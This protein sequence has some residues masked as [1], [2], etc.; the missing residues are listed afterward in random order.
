MSTFRGRMKEFPGVCVDYFDKPD[1]ETLY[2]L[3]HCH[4]DHMIGIQSLSTIPNAKLIVSKMT[5]SILNNVYP[6]LEPILETI[7]T[8]NE[9]LYTLT[10]GEQILCTAL[11][12]GHCPGSV[13]FYFQTETVNVLYTGDFRWKTSDLKQLKILDRIKQD[14]NAIYIDSTF[15][16]PEF[17]EFPGQKDSVGVVEKLVN[18]WLKLSPNNNRVFLEI[19]ARFGSEYLLLELYKRLHL[20]MH[21]CDVDQGCLLPFIPEM[22]HFIV[23]QLNDSVKIVVGMR[24]TQL[25]PRFQ[26]RRI[27]PSAMYWANWKQGDPVMKPDDHRRELFR[28]CYSSHSSC[29]EIM[30]LLNLLQPHSINL[31][32]L[33][34]GHK[35]RRLDQLKLFKLDKLQQ[36][37]KN[38]KATVDFSVVDLPKISFAA[39]YVAPVGDKSQRYKKFL[40]QIKADDSDE[41]EPVIVLP[42]RKRIRVKE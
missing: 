31:N 33:P 13:M 29:S 39:G 25:N 11:P 20:D 36:A 41:E 2:F 15:M 7:D 40:A 19:P 17:N 38:K 27:R 26:W 32:V 16:V 3:S 37:V 23:P 10:N 14:L 5:Q 18:E 42:I 9:K 21:L 8:G 6:E 1:E 30:A 12:A 24:N 4:T 28:I 34:D 35:D 22:K